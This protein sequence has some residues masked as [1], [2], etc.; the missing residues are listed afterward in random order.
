MKPVAIR[1]VALFV[2]S[3]LAILLLSGCGLESRDPAEPDQVHA[4][5]PPSPARVPTQAIP[6]E[7]S[8]HVSETK[9]TG[10]ERAVMRTSKGVITL[11]FY[12]ED[13]PNTVANFI[14]LVEAGFYDGLRFH[15][16]IPGFMAQGGDPLTR[17]LSAEDVRAGVAGVGTGDPGWKQKAEFNA[18]THERGTLAMARSQAVDSAGSQFY[19][20]FEPQ[21][22]LDGNYTVFGKVVSGME[23]VDTIEVGDVIE[24]VTI[25][26]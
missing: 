21:P 9:V 23:V 12:P 13:A 15:R 1:G 11:E 17:G 16:V 24:S 14:D 8:M 20:C 10:T 25:E 18:R 5:A 19:I 7:D 3:L 2:V 26:R 6:E 4:E 22:H